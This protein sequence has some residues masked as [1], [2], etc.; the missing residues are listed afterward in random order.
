M[1]PVWIALDHA[2]TT[3]LAP[4][5]FSAMRPWLEDAV[6]NPASDHRAGR[7]ARAAVESAREAV[8]ELVGT[9]A[10]SLIWTSGA[11]ESIN[12]AIKG[13]LAFHGDTQAHVVSSRIEHRATLDTL[14][15]VATQGHKVTLLSPDRYGQINVD[16]VMA[17]LTPAT[18]LVSLMWV[19]NELGTCTDVPTLAAA[20]RARGVLLHI[21][22]AQ[23][24]GWLPINL[25]ETPI[26]LL[27]LSA[28]K[29]GG[30][31]A[32]AHWWSGGARGCGSAPCCTAA[33]RS[34]A[35]A[36]EPWP[37]IR[38]SASVRRRSTDCR[39]ARRWRPAPSACASGWPHG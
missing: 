28:H 6:G 33:V 2:A 5:V 39:S 31:K 24:A 15:W 11:T 20:L 7:A 30:R 27:S 12:L 14:R 9:P 35:C 22:A 13:A 38:L 8:A 21:D 29:L 37:R 4:G 10:D 3:P 25:S 26:D 32:L 34:R 18:R 16:A 17:A 36:R 23:A 1:T 19:N